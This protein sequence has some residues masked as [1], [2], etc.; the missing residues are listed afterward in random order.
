MCCKKKRTDD[1]WNVDANR[2]LSDSWT[3]FTKFTSLKEKPQKGFMWSG[4]RLTK[5]Q[6]T[7]RRDRLWPEIWTDMLKAAHKKDKQEWTI[8]Q[9]KLVNARRLRGI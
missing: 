5:I 9:P 7:T 8:E 4:G 2:S 6:A 1:Y 3:G